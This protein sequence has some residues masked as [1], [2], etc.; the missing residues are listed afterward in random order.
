MLLKA[1]ASV[2]LV[3]DT[4][5]TPLYKA[6]ENG[7]TEIV[8]MLISAKA[9]VNISDKDGDTA[10]SAAAYCGHADT[11]QELIRAGANLEA[12]Y[13][14]HTSP[15]SWAATFGHVPVIELLIQ[16]GANVNAPDKLGRTPLDL[17]M[18]HTDIHPAA[19]K[20]ASFLLRAAG[21]Y[22]GALGLKWSKLGSSRPE[23]SEI[24]NAALA[25]ALY[26]SAMSGDHDEVEF[27][28]DEFDQFHVT[29]LSVDS[30][31]EVK[32]SKVSRL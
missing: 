19:S 5:Q 13:P 1:G 27:T 2:H 15:I 9:D 4:K 6:A 16:A 29:N 8:K 23:G 10:I 24:R 32:S 14:H 18:L 26:K 31:I 28:R 22:A 17:A 20:R 25:K 30:Y 21:A 11:V 12:V 7:H 3:N